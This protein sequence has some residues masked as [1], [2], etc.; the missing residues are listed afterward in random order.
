MTEEQEGRTFKQIIE[1]AEH[2]AGFD[3][4][5]VSI[6]ESDWDLILAGMAQMQGE[7]ID[8]AR[9]LEAALNVVNGVVDWSKE[10]RIPQT[11]TEITLSG[12]LR[13]FT[14]AWNESNLLIREEKPKVEIVH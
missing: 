12:K 11:R 14:K 9:I 1:D 7:Y 5:Y 13:D 2:V 6:K 4:V 10:H 3:G 8:M